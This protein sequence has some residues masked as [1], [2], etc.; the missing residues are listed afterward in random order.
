MKTVL[1]RSSMIPGP[2]VIALT[3]AQLKIVQELAR[4]LQRWQRDRFLQVVARRLA[5][6]TIGD[7]AVH[8][9]AVAGHKQ[10]FPSLDGALERTG[11]QLRRH[12]RR[13]AGKNHARSL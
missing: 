7:G 13:Q 12:L 4:P 5:G 2:L 10:R 9:A 11:K 6:E 8:H 3:D 1:Q